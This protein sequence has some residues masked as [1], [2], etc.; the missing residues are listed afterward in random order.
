MGQKITLKLAGISFAINVET[1]EDERLVRLAADDISKAVNDVQSLYPNLP[2]ERVFALIA[3]NVRRNDLISSQR[4]DKLKTEISRL[5]A[6]F[7]EYLD[8]IDTAVS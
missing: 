4:Q 8:N 7:E 3:L 6:S 2:L 5:E 1:E